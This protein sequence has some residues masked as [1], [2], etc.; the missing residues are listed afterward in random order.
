MRIVLAGR[1][2]A[3]RA[4]RAKM[5]LGVIG[6]GTIATL[7]LKTL[8]RELPEPLAGVCI[9][10]RPGNRERALNVLVQCSS[11][12]C[13]E[14]TVTESIEEFL[15][16]D[17][18]VIAEAASHGALESHGAKILAAGKPLI[19]TSVGALADDRLRP[20]L[21][22][23]AQQGRTSW[24]AIPGAAGGLDILRAA[25]L[26]GL[27]EVIY[28]SRKPPAAWKGTK[29]Q[30]L[31]DL[32]NAKSETVFFEGA[33]GQAARDY[34]QNANVAAT[35]AL[36]GAGFEK[37]RVRMIADPSVSRNV[38][39]LHVRAKCAEFTIRIEGRPAPEN[40]KTSLTTAYSLA[41]VL[42]QRLHAS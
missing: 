34:P 4:V 19:I 35:I 21:D 8:A 14:S 20:A 28:V 42:L 24:E 25:K 9:L 39:E 1:L 33:A 36:A 13:L 18:H 32:D 27:D 2:R 26:S 11:K 22:A 6:Y 5:R 15:R 40:P 10:T 37:T 3:Q 41:D 38:H 30:T 31:V 12:L 23:A 17:P 29:A 7:A 16:H